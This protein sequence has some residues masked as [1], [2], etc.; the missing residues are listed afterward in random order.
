MFWFVQGDAASGLE[1]LDEDRRRWSSGAL[2]RCKEEDEDKKAN[3]ESEKRTC[4]PVYKARRIS[5]KRGNR[6]DKKM[7]M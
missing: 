1:A 4:G 5:G 3:G 2:E 7:D 6:G